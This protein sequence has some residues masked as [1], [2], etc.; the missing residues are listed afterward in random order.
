MTHFKRYRLPPPPAP[1]EYLEREIRLLAMHCPAIKAVVSMYDTKQC[2]WEEAMTTAAL[3]L[4][5]QESTLLKMATDAAM[6]APIS[7][8]LDSEPKR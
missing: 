2:T 6:R 4:G 8:I 7:I 3:H 1:C 5:Q